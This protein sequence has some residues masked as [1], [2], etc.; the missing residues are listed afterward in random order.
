M[1]AIGSLLKGIIA[2]A[3]VTAI[4]WIGAL[5]LLNVA[6]PLGCEALAPY[7]ELVK[8]P[9]PLLGEG[10]S[11]A[12]LLIA[13]LF[14]GLVIV[15]TPRDMVISL[16]AVFAILIGAVVFLMHMTPVL[17]AQEPEPEPVVTPAPELD[18]AASELPILEPAR[19]APDEFLSED[20]CRKCMVTETVTRP[21]RLDFGPVETGAFWQYAKDR[22]VISGGQAMDVDSFV[23]SLASR[24][25]FCSAEAV[26]VFGSASSDGLRSVNEQR[27]RRRAE[28]LA[29]AVREACGP[30]GPEIFALSLGQSEAERD[31]DEDRPVTI[32]AIRRSNGYELTGELILDELG[33]E[34]AEGRAVSPLL[35]RRERFPHPWSGPNGTAS[36][37]EVKPRPVE[38]R[39]VPAPGA[40]ESCGAPDLLGVDGR[41]PLRQ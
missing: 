1:G 36:A 27:A 33:Y 30:S 23:R 24:A 5:L 41:P 40:P 38:T 6:C 17:E 20:G 14:L 22:T 13:I 7:S 15:L 16:A 4:V 11:M 34:L 9:A 37:L 25:D 18:A 21:P 12:M 19:C 8:Q 32:T 26:L 3:V 39:M 35:E 31:V 10:M 2:A 29:D 28:N